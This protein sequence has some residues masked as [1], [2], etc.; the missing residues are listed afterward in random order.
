MRFTILYDGPL[1]AQTSHDGRIDYKQKIRRE[2]HRQLVEVWKSKPMLARYYEQFMKMSAEERASTFQKPGN[3]ARQRHY[4][5]AVG[6]RGVSLRPTGIQ[7]IMAS[8]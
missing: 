8:V 7:Q 5:D 1:P 3:E 6:L 2:F 4:H